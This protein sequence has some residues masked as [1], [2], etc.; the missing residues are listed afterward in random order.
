MQTRVHAK[1]AAGKK[2]Q[3]KKPVEPLTEEDWTFFLTTINNSKSFAHSK[4]IIDSKAIRKLGHQML[5][6][7]QSS[8]SRPETA[9]LKDEDKQILHKMMTWK[10]K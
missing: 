7:T 1:P 9:I 4:T 5:G 10:K 6:L 2:G 8:G 3:K